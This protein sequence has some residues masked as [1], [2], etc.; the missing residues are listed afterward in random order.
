M[1]R[2]WALLVSSRRG[3]LIALGGLMETLRIL[4]SIPLLI[5]DAIWTVLTRDGD[6][7]ELQRIRQDFLN[8]AEGE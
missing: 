3:P 2:E 7:A 1:H 5:A 6:E 4:V 8:L